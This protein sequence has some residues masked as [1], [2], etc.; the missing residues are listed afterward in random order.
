MKKYMLA[1]L[2][3]FLLAGGYVLAE[4]IQRFEY[5]SGTEIYDLQSDG[6]Q[7]IAGDVRLG[8]DGTAETTSTSSGNSQGI[9][10]PVKIHAD[11]SAVL[12]GSVLVANPP[13]SSGG[14]VVVSL[15]AA[16]NDLTTIVGIAAEAG[17]AGDVIDMYISGFV[18]ARTTGTVVAGNTLVSTTASAGYLA[19]DAT[20]T[21]GADVAVALSTGTAAGGLTK[22]LLYK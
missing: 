3:G 8:K 15:G 16:T 6:T 12:E 19:A 11:S 13:T 7:G 10:I 20:P 14:D 21:T 9:M 4:S 1:L 22:V 18:L 17:S 2:A 5:P